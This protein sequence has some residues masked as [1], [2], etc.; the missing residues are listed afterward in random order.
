[1]KLVTKHPG[2][3]AA[4]G[5]ILAAVTSTVLVTAAADAPT[6]AGTAVISRVSISNFSFQPA[7]LTVKAGTRVTWANHDSTPHTVTSS[8]KR[9]SSSGGLD[10]NDQYSVLFDEPGTYEY[11]CSLHPMMTGKVIVRSGH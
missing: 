3:A 6:P 1:M 10:T 5:L 4:L 7:V 9:F 8:D 2:R 11:F